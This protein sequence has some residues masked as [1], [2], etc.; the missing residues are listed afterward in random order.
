MV[1]SLPGEQL[2][3]C[4]PLPMYSSMDIDF[5]EAALAPGAGGGAHKV[6]ATVT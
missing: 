2:L 1:W 3:V 4:Q 5:S 6:V